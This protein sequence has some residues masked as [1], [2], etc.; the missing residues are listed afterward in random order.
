MENMIII[1]RIVADSWPI[2]VMIVA[3]C[4]SVVIRRS[5]S[6]TLDNERF[7]ELNRS[8]GNHAVVVQPSRHAD[9]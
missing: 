1:L 3:L 8:S 9:D 4:G 6:Q 5:V 7:K 2:T